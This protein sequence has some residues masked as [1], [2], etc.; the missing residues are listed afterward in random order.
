VFLVVKRE[1]VEAYG[2]R[3]G[4]SPLY[5]IITSTFL[6]GGIL[7]LA[8]NM[9]YLW[10]FG[11]AVEDRLGVKLYLCLYFLAGFA[12]DV[13]QG[14]L[15]S[16]GAIAAAVPLIGAS[17]CIMGVLGAYWYLYAWSPVCIFYWVS[18][19]WR[20]TFEVAAVWVI[21]FYFLMDLANGFVGRYAGQVGGV[22]NFAH[23]GGVLAGLM[24]VW[25]L[26]IKRDSDQVS[27]VKAIQAECQDINL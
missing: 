21:G 24:L 14:A 26:G 19:I 1:V 2:L 10:I 9:L 20:G 25:A 16:A 17:A 12:G 23:V 7:H 11:P 13:A 18:L 22:A 15:A 6:H 3:W 27:R 4:L 5:T 8:G